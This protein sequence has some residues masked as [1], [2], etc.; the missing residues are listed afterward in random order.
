MSNTKKQIGDEIIACTDEIVE[1]WYQAWR[2]S[3]H[4]HEDV[5]EAALKDKLGL[6]LQIIGEQLL[7]LHKAENPHEMWKIT[8]RLDPELRIGQDVPI[9]EVVQEYR[10]AVET[11]RDWI[12]DAGIDVSFAEY[13]FFYAS[14]FEL[15]AESVKRYS[16][17][18][19]DRTRHD[20]AHYLAGV[21]HQLRGPLSGLTMEVE[22]LEHVAPPPDIESMTRLRRNV[23]RLRW[24]VDRILR[25]ERFRPCEAPVHP[26]DVRP[27]HL[28]DDIMSDHESAAARKS[29]RFEAH[30]NR[31]LRMTLDPGLFLDAL[32]NLVGNA[33]KFTRQGFVI[34]DTAEH[35]D[36]VVFCVRD[37]GP[38]IPPERR[39]KLFTQTLSGQAGGAGIGLQ[40]AQ[41][42]AQAMGGEI[43]V[44]DGD[45]N[46]SVFSLRIPRTVP[47][48]EGS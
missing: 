7:E 18:Q 29:L 35:P 6:Q 5:S 15:T 19:A 8:E 4:P 30:V 23:R 26:E 28:I 32:G 17:H 44:E 11:V 10:L 1:R 37:S 21:M 20:R 13:S 12:E 47:A 48:R 40:I 42:A 41:H 24:L 16:E 31:S 39:E 34:V 14:I 36:D 38:G 43:K 3:E 33:V 22:M 2:A 45:E 25:L 9:E 27:A 46:G